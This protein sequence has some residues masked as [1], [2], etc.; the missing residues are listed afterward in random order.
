M[1]DNQEIS[2]EDELRLQVN[3]LVSEE[4]ELATMEHDLMTSN[5]QVG[6]F[7]QKQKEFTTKQAAFFQVIED[8]MINNNIK[9]I[10]DWWGSLTIAERTNYKAPNIDDVPPRFIKKALDTT[11]ISAEFKLKN[12]LPKGIESS[13]SLFLQKR[14]KLDATPPEEEEKI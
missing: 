14:I 5:P 2:I 12:K 7:L 4:K 13:Q 11:K 8:Q 3:E 6:R 9:S 10:K 1:A